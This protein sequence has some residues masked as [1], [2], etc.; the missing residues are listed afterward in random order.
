[1]IPVLAILLGAAMLVWPAALNGYPLVFI[2]SVSY[3]GQ[4]LFPEWPWDK[5]P[6]YGAFLHLFHWGWSLWVPLAAQGLILSHLLWLTQRGLRGE[7]TALGH[8]LLCAALAALTSAP[9]FAATLMPD[10]L[11]AIGPLCLLLLG[12]ARD[13]LSAVEA[14][15]LVLLGALAIA[16]HLSHLPTALALMVFIGVAGRT[17]GAGLR[18]ALPL[19]IAIVGLVAANA[20]ATGRPTLSPN[21]AVFLLARLQ[22]DGPAAETIRAHCPAAGWRLCGFADRLPM[23][24]NTFLWDPQSPLNR[25]VTGSPIAMG[26]VRAAPE[27]QAILEAT[28]REHP[29]AVAEAMARNTLAQLQRFAVGD[30]LGAEHLVASARRAVERMPASELAAFD[31][32]AQMRGEL[33]ALAMPWLTLQPAIVLLSLPLALFALLRAVRRRDRTAAGLIAG[34]LL[35]VVVNAFATGALSGPADRYQARIIW[36]VPLAAALGLAPR[37]GLGLTDDEQLRSRI[38][39]WNTSSSSSSPSS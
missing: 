12:F 10:L 23:D 6:A 18:A 15:W 25:S 7:A 31:A 17:I 33:P 21:G 29:R 26:G 4:T 2:D 22:A 9:W 35:A 5:T 28:F 24:S 27:A 11:T 1:M 37:F 16:T 14:A 34:L 39:A 32:A 20:W 36:L 19:V 38:T 8:G 13:R 3:L 30:T